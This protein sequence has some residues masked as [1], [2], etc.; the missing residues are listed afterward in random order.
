VHSKPLE[1]PLFCSMQVHCMLV[2][3]LMVKQILSLPPCIVTP[4]PVTSI[5]DSCGAIR[6]LICWGGKMHV[7]AHCMQVQ[8]RLL[9]S[10]AIRCCSSRQ[11]L[12]H[13]GP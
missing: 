6:C 2:I 1:V 7:Q 3:V 4:L 5:G 13:G 10:S 12:H 8:E 9:A 11:S